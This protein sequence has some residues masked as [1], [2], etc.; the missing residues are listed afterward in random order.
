VGQKIEKKNSVIE[1]KIADTKKN[2]GILLGVG[3]K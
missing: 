1:M 2:R 3:Q